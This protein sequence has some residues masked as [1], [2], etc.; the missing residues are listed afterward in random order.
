MAITLFILG[1]WQTKFAKE[2]KEK[3]TVK[4]NIDA[5]I[6]SPHLLLF[7]ASAVPRANFCEDNKLNVLKLK[8]VQEIVKK[9]YTLSTY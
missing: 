7:K 1:V 5:F 8:I 4:N 2:E 3:S 6:K 9:N